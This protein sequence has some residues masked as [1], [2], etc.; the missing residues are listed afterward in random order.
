M[1]PFAVYRVSNKVKKALESK[2]PLTQSRPSQGK[3]F[4]CH[5]F[6]NVPL[7]SAI[8]GDGKPGFCP[9]SLAESSRLSGNGALTT[10]GLQALDPLSIPL[11]AKLKSTLIKEQE[12]KRLESRESEGIPR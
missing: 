2:A 10:L 12:R 6:V 7:I 11:S 3:L 8:G 5:T 4:F 1:N 9:V